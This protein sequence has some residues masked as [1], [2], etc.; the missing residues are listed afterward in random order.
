MSKHPSGTV[1]WAQDPTQAHPERP[2]IVLSHEDRP[3]SGIECTV[4]CLGTEAQKYDHPTPELE[5]KH[6][7]GITFGNPTYLLPW[8]LYT[9]PPGSLLEGKPIGQLSPEGEK[10]VAESLYKLVR[11]GW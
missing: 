4:V 11:G 7:T 6:L 9:I 10:L 3:F 2:V 5:D 1:T 8:A